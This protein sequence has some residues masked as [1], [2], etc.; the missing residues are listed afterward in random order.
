MN[1]RF[2]VNDVEDS[3]K[4]AIDAI[5]KEIEE[6][7][8]LIDNVSVI[9][10]NLDAKIERR[11]AEID[12][13]ERRLETLNKV[14]PAFL[15][16]FNALEQEMEKIFLQYSTKLRCLNYLESLVGDEER[17]EAQRQQL[18]AAKKNVERISLN[19]GELEHSEMLSLGGISPE[20]KHI[21]LSRPERPRASTGGK[22]HLFR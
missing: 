2:E 10:V 22:F 18:I 12:R 20:Q 5:K 19:S 8:Q 4:K 16:E 11:K 1:R 14:R 6:T 9:E 17:A 21:S 13:Y 7:N 15:E 3:I